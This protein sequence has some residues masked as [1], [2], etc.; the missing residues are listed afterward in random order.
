MYF[1]RGVEHEIV[2][3]KAFCPNIV[4]R[5]YISGYGQSHIIGH[6]ATT[7]QESAGRIGKLYDLLDAAYY[8][9]F[10]FVSSMITAP[11]KL[12]LSMEAQKSPITPEIVPLPM[13]HAQKRGW[14][15][16]IG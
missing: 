13:Y 16:P 14:I 6:R 1:G 7:N 5:F 2:C 11:P 12:G 15:L 8:L 3:F 4:A 10:N 9:L